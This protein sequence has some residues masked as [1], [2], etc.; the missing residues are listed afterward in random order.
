MDSK[1]ILNN[2]PRVIISGG[3]TGGHIFPAVSIANEIRSRYPGAGIL[4][5]G[6]LGR[7]EM[8][9]IPDAGYEIVGLNITGM[10]RKLSWSN[11][12]LPFKLISSVMKARTIIKDF[13]PDVVVGTGGFASA[14]LMMAARQLRIPA[15]VQEQNSY[16]GITN[17]RIGAKADRICVA[18]KGMEKFFPLQ[19]IRLTGNPVRKDIL[20]LNGKRAQALNEFGFSSTSRTLLILGGS[21]GARTINDSILAGFNR[22]ADSQIQVVWQTGKNYYNDVQSQMKGQDLRKVR[23][24]DFI[25]NMDMAYAAA[26]VVITRAGALAIAELCVAGKPC[27]LVPSPNVAE[28]HQTKNAEALVKENAGLVVTDA[29]TEKDLISEALRLIFDE[30]RCAELSRNILQLGKPKATEEIVNE[31][32]ALIAKR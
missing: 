30:E 26:D 1:N 18:Y 2:Q 32:E 17:K 14:P 28:D 5:V 22:L 8:T 25:K 12:A 27:I 10:Q 6:A 24:F 23:L 16:A 4:F 7:M 31:L 11:L 3:G 13:K 15:L 19:K 9:R 29:A 21:L 20:N